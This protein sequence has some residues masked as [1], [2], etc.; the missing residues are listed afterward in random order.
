MTVAELERRMDMDEFLEWIA[1]YMAP[2]EAKKEADI[3][4]I[5]DMVRIAASGNRP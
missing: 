4:N 1:Y 3:D 5:K 2:I